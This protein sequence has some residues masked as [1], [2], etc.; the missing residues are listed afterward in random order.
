M[1]NLRNA[2]IDAEPEIVGGLKSERVGGARGNVLA[3]YGV[4]GSWL[5]AVRDAA[6]KAEWILAIDRS[7]MGGSSREGSDGW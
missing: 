3:V 5:V 1:I 6:V 4:G 2:T 7:F